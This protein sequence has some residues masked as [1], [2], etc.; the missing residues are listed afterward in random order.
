MRNQDPNNGTKWE[1]GGGGGG[2]VVTSVG[3]PGTIIVDGES[4]P[5]N[6]IVEVG[7]HRPPPPPPPPPPFPIVRVQSP[8]GAAPRSLPPNRFPSGASPSLNDSKLDNSRLASKPPGPMPGA[9][10]DWTT[11]T[12]W[13]FEPDPRLFWQPITSVDTGNR[14]LNV[15]LNKIL[16]PWINALAAVVNIPR[17]GQIVVDDF[18]SH[19]IINVEYRDAAYVF[20][21]MGAAGVAIEASP[22]LE[23]ISARVSTWWSAFSKNPAVLDTLLSPIFM[24]FGAETGA[25]SGVGAEIESTLPAQVE[26]SLPNVR[27]ADS[28]LSENSR[29]GNAFQRAVTEAFGLERNNNTMVGPELESGAFYPTIPDIANG[30]NAPIGD[31]KD[32]LNISLTRQLRLQRDIAKVTGT[33]FSVIASPRTRTVSQPLADAVRESGGFIFKANPADKTV[34]VWDSSS[35][36]WVPFLSE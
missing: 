22:A 28:I 5:Y 3:G 35:R 16:L 11:Q 31:I 15:V 6:E 26:S 20:P 33:S 12:E 9:V 34:K 17:A 29:R 30:G 10:P 13:R 24:S 21:T 32:V 4:I 2:L 25:L 14:P 27:T 7:P 36:S 19:S 1:G 8:D 23:F 18:L